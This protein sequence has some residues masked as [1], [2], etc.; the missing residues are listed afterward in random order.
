MDNFYFNDMVISSAFGFPDL[1]ITFTCNPNWPEI[2]RLLSKENLKPHDRPGI[3]VKVF[4]IKFD[5][6]MV[7]LTKR[8]MLGKV[9]TYMLQLNSRKG[10]CHMHTFL[11]SYTHRVSILHRETLTTSSLQKSLI[12]FCIRGYI[13]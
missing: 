5:E 7:D 12:L 1:F 9:S 13:N 11:F 6:L 2:T 10:A 3:I 8:H 4:K